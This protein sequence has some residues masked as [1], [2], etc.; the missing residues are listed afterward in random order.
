MYSEIAQWVERLLCTPGEL[1][2]D[3]RT[4]M[5]AGIRAQV[6]VTLALLLGS[7]WAGELLES[8]KITSLRY[9]VLVKKKTLFLIRWATKTDTQVVL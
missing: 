5:K 9:T 3:P 7:R 2:S 8:R 1:S 4:F 6:S